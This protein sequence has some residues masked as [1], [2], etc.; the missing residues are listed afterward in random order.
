MC[1]IF[2]RPAPVTPN[3]CAIAS[4]Y[5]LVEN[6]LSERTPSIMAYGRRASNGTPMMAVGGSKTFVEDVEHSR[7]IYDSWSDHCMS[8]SLS[9]RR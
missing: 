4:V 1:L 6:G 9:K 2:E 7:T 8:K 5:V 3:I